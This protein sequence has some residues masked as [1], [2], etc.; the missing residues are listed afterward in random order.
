VKNVRVVGYREFPAGV[1]CSH[2]VVVSP[3][4]S[5]P[6]YFLIKVAYAFDDLPPDHQTKSIKKRDA[7]I[8]L[9]GVASYQARIVSN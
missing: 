3:P 1:P 6:E 5:V 4:I 7:R 9:T 2:A 8:H